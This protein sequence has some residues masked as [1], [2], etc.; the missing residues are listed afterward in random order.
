LD[1]LLISSTSTFAPN[2]ADYT[3]AATTGQVLEKI[4]DKEISVITNAAGVAVLTFSIATAATSFLAT[5]LP[6]GEMVVSAA[7]THV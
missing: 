5:K 4:A 6:G 1:I 2:A 3:I 7:M